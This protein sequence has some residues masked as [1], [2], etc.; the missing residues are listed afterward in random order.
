MMAKKG[1]V[2]NYELIHDGGGTHINTFTYKVTCDEL[3]ATGTGR[4]KKDAKHEAANAMLT[5]IAAHRNYPQLPASPA[6]SPV[7][8]PLPDPLPVSPRLPANVPF[9]N[10]I[11]ALQDLCAENNLQEPEYFPV[12]DLGP[13]HARVFTIRC[14]VSN[15]TETGVGKTKKQ[16][17][18]D[19]AKKMAD[20]INNIIMDKLKDISMESSSQ[21]NDRPDKKLNE[22]AESKY[23]VVRKLISSR[24]I[25]LGVKLTEYHTIMRDN[26]DADL[27]CKI[28]EE[29]HNLIPDHLTLITD[30]LITKKLSEL[31]NLLSEANISF[32]LQDLQLT[33]S[34]ESSMMI[35]LDTCPPITQIGIGKTEAEAIFK[36]LSHIIST[37]KLL[38]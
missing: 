36:A 16:A 34:N 10:T 14:V 11:G 32:I 19:A 1:T 26:L 25:N 29:L 31:Q 17:K 18:H 21:N 38:L 35:Q 9:V 3:T 6:K 20:R 4:C 12:S 28:L 2:P 15:F 22:I 23:C 5:T 37:L 13:P 7:S 27:R 30:E 24:K 8:T 33:D